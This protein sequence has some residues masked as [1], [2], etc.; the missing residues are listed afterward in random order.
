MLIGGVLTA[1]GYIS[2]GLINSI[3]WTYATFSVLAGKNL[4]I[5]LVSLFPLTAP[6]VTKYMS[7]YHV[8]QSFITGMVYCIF[9]SIIQH[10]K[11]YQLTISFPGKLYIDLSH[12]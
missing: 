1:L 4:Y 6:S 2:C 9:I 12:P 10:S 8:Y 3:I 11:G 7:R 5:I